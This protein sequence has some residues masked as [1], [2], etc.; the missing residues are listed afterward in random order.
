MKFKFNY[1]RDILLRYKCVSFVCEETGAICQ[2]NYGRGLIYFTE[3]E[4]KDRR[5]ASRSNDIT[6]FW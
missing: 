4:L 6:N 3:S 1:R 2:N 5:N